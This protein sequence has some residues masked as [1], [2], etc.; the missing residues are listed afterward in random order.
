MLE[1]IGQ[2]LGLILG[3]IVLGVML[4]VPDVATLTGWLTSAATSTPSVITAAPLPPMGWGGF[5]VDSLAWGLGT[6]VVG[7]GLAYAYHRRS[8]TSSDEV[9]KIIYKTYQY[10]G[11]KIV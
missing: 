3:L 1:K 10:R 6:V 11:G 8:S 9:A 5:S 2:I 7:G 4:F